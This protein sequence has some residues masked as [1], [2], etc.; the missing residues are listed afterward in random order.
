MTLDYRTVFISDTHLGSRGCRAAALSRFLKHARCERLY[1][2]GDIV[3]MWRLRQK[4][5]WPGEHNDVLRRILNQTRHGTDV[6]FVPG[7][8][9]EGARQFLHTNFGGVRILPYAVHVRADGKRLLVI[10]GD[11]F[12][13]VVKHSR[14]VSMAG[15]WA[16][17]GLIRLNRPF[18]AVRR[19]LGL[20]Y[21]SLSKSIKNRVKSACMFISKFE[22]TLIYEA[23]RRGLDGV[24]CGHIHAPEARGV[25]AGGG[26]SDGDTLYYNCGDWI[27]NCTAVVE[28]HDGRMEVI[29]AVAAVDN[30]LAASQDTAG[31]PDPLAFA[32]LIRSD[33]GL[34]LDQQ[35]RVTL[36]GAAVRRGGNL[37]E[38]GHAD[39]SED[40]REHG[41]ARVFPAPR[42]QTPAPRR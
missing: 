21:H 11:Q 26:A 9:D 34:E 14:L 22:E 12:D 32:D 40:R 18:N 31:Q 24:V 39:L 17:D 3:D 38:N 19:R 5:Y 23:T 30:M 2:V 27:E 41:A 8:H 37:L 25:A 7:N 13:M 15:A 36:G 28:H 29:D 6:V 10:H 1:L 35:W 20:P 4:W 42:P 16:Y 33:R